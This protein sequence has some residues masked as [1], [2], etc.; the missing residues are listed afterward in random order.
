MLGVIELKGN[1]FEI[2]LFFI[3]I[4]ILRAFSLECDNVVIF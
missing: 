4:S 3:A 1:I 2:G